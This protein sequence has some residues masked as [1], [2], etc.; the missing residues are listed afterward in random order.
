MAQ[1]AKRLTKHLAILVKPI[2]RGKLVHTFVY[3]QRERERERE[4]IR[5]YAG[6]SSQFLFLFFSPAFYPPPLDFIHATGFRGLEGR[7]RRCR[8]ALV[9][10]A[11][12]NVRVRRPQA[13]SS[14]SAGVYV[15]PGED[16][17]GAAAFVFIWAIPT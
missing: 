3:P 16:E 12:C 14:I 9:K 7:R 10:L 2:E 1:R 11:V 5:M 17:R 15:Y 6:R 13:R 4:A 8:L